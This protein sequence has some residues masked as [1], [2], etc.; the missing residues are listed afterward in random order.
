[1][2]TVNSL[3]GGQTV[4]EI[5]KTAL[6]KGLS[7][8]SITDHVDMWFYDKKN[9]EEKIK[10]CIKQ[11]SDMQK[12]YL[13]KLKIFLH[14]INFPKV[15]VVFTKLIGNFYGFFLIFKVF[16]TFL[17]IFFGISIVF[18]IRKKNSKISFRYVYI[19]KIL[20]NFKIV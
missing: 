8:V 9:T 3:D 10:N 14:L 11:V 16:Y 1:M 15:E 20:R 18:Q 6:E 2:H 19:P 17:K 5:C 7:G 12:K 13:G 4:D